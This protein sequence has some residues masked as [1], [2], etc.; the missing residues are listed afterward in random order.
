MAGALFIFT[1]KE[2]EMRVE[3]SIEIAAPPEKIWSFIVEPEKVVKWSNFSRFEYTSEQRSGPGTLIYL[4]EKAKPLPLMKFSFA[5]T[6]WI[7]NEKLVSKLNSGPRILKECAAK[8]LVEAIPSGSR[9]TYIETVQFSFGV[10]GRL[11]G[12]IGQRS[13]N[14]NTRKTLSRLKSAVEA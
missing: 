2:T 10:I 13:A 14:T 7:E 11:L 4:E 1:K 3:K 8:W 9:V 6:E 12:L 5:V